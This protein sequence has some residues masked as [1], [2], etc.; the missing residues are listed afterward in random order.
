MRQEVGWFDAKQNSTGIL[1]GKL[2]TEATQVEGAVGQPLGAVI[3]CGC[4]IIT[5]LVIAYIKAWRLAWVI[6]LVFPFIL[7][8]GFVEVRSFLLRYYELIV[9]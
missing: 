6:T 4:A 7:L 2:S 5:G 1:T 3:T 8:G 9:Y